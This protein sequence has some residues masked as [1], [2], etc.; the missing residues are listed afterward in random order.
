MLKS[1][2]RKKLET[3]TPPRALVG[4]VDVVLALR[5]VELARLGRDEHVVVRLL[6]VIDARLVDLEVHRR[7]RREILDEQHRQAFRRD[8]VHR[9]QRDAV[10]VRE[11]QPLVDP[12]AVRQAVG[13]QLARRQHDL[14][15][16]AVDHVPIVVH[17]DEVVVR[18]DFL[19]LRERLQQ[20]L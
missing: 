8:L 15:I 7:L 13:V 3:G 1:R 19:D 18:A 4:R 2:R 5:V 6:P 14:P 17:R 10:A 11:R 12:V 16:L 9:S 20:R